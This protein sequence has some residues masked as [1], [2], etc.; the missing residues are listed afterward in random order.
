MKRISIFLMLLH[1]GFASFTQVTKSL[2]VT[3][4]GDMYKLLN[5]TEKTTITKL[6]LS[7]RIRRNK[8]KE[9]AGFL[10]LINAYHRSE[11]K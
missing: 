10:Q 6:T 9:H 8:F 7:G 1:V 4:A 11:N 2:N 3:T 5:F